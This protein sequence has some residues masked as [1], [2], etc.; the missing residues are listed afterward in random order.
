LTDIARYKNIK[1]PKDVVRN[2]LRLRN[3]IDYLGLWETINNPNFKGIE[4]DSFKSEAGTNAFTL[5][6]QL[7]I[8]KTNA[9]GII[10]KS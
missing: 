7:W 9:I 8:E 2:W 10:S 6:P 5:S 4:F 1:E 3:T